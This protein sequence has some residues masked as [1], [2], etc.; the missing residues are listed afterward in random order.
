MIYLKSVTKLAFFTER[1]MEE[2]GDWKTESGE[3]TGEPS[4]DCRVKEDEELY[5]VFF[6]AMLVESIVSRCFLLPMIDVNL[7][8][9]NTKFG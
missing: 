1:R 6:G 9:N 5:L 3:L 7:E 2:E 4:G 8:R